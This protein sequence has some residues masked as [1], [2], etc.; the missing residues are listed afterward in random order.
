MEN[1]KISV[2]YSK[3]LKKKEGSD[4]YRFDLHIHTPAS[5]CYTSSCPDIVDPYVIG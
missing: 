5:K 3:L 1:N 4:Y 2:L